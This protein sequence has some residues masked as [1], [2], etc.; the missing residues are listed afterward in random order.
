MPLAA[1][2]GKALQLVNILRDMP[3]DLRAG[4]C[5]LPADEL[6]AAGADP[7]TI[8][9]DPSA[10]QPVFDAWMEKGARLPRRRP[11]IHPRH[12]PVARPFRVLRPV[13]ARRKT[14]AHGREAAAH[15]RGKSE[16]LAHDGVRHDAPRPRRRVHEP[17]LR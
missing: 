17:P 3:A 13:A 2:F 15:Q 4:R 9:D 11:R 7:A 1:S 10:A 5:Y 12:P 16:G 8:L 6:Q 14:L